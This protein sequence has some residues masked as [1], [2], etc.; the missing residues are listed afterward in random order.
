MTE[1]NNKER[2]REFY[3]INIETLFLLFVD[4]WVFLLR[5]IKKEKRLENNR[6]QT[7]Q[8]LFEC[9]TQCSI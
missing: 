6:L 8:I 2:E 9:S 7:L 4:F 3:Y 1:F 5:V